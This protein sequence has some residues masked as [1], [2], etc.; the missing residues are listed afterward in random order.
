MDDLY[1]TD[2]SRHIDAAHA[3]EYIASSLVSLDPEITPFEQ[4]DDA[5][6]QTVMDSAFWLA[7]LAS[8]GLLSHAVPQDTERANDLL[9]A[10]ADQHHVAAN[11]ALAYRYET[12][13]TMEK[14]CSM[15]Y[16]HLKVCT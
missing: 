9:Q 12:G 16:A 3:F 14:S 7:V 2:A 8:S 15:A 13:Y 4:L 1:A 6:K 10:A 5:S 11:M